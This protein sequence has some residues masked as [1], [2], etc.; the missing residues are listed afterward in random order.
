MLPMSPYT[1]KIVESG[2]EFALSFMFA[3]RLYET[4]VTFVNYPVPSHNPGPIPE[5]EDDPIDNSNL[6]EPTH[7]GSDSDD[8]IT[9]TSRNDIILG[10]TGDDTLSGGAGSDTYSIS[11][12]K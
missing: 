9:G 4:S 10:G 11:K 7:T 6:P 5:L 8:T 2:H 12:I 3:K 1:E